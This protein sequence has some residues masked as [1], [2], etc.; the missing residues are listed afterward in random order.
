MAVIDGYNGRLDANYA[1][2][3]YPAIIDNMR[4]DD[5][6]DLGEPE[7]EEIPENKP[8]HSPQ[9]FPEGKP[10]IEIPQPPVIENETRSPVITGVAD[11]ETPFEMT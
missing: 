2:L 1:Y 11:H 9:V 6:V 3:D 8:E 10:E 7:V 5:M 4:K